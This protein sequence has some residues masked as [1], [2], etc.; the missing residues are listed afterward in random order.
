MKYSVRDKPVRA[1]VRAAVPLLRRARH[2]SELKD[3]LLVASQMG[4]TDA[5]TTMKHYAHL[6]DEDD[7]LKRLR[8]D[9]STTF[10][11][12]VNPASDIP[13]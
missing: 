9:L 2:L 5:R 7:A 10:G 11:E 6:V 8:D 1:S 3:A 12:T 4:H 13:C